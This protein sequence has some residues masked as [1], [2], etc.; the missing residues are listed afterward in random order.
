MSVFLL[1]FN[2]VLVILVHQIKQKWKLEMLPWQL[3]EIK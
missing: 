2:Y 3:A 1:I